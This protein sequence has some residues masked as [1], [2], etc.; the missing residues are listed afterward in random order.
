MDHWKHVLLTHWGIDAQ[1]R[2][3]DGEYDLNFLAETDTG[4]GY[5][6]KAMRPG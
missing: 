2:R 3:L 4:D 5:V 6:L 1:L